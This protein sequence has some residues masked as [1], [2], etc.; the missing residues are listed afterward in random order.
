[1]RLAILNFHEK[2]TDSLSLTMCNIVTYINKIFSVKDVRI[3]SN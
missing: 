3:Y 1:M 2:G